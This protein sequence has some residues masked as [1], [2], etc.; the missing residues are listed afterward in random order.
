MKVQP[1]QMNPAVD[2]G[3]HLANEQARQKQELAQ[4][5]TMVTKN[6]QWMLGLLVQHTAELPDVSLLKALTDEAF[7]W[8]RYFQ[9]Q[10]EQEADNAGQP[11]HD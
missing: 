4:R 7:A 10:F 2:L 8:S 5:V 11:A 1:L 3:A 9:Q 6:A